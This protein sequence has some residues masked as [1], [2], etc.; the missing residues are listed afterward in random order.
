MDNIYH[1]TCIENIGDRVVKAKCGMVAW[2]RV[3]LFKISEKFNLN[4]EK[5]T[6][7]RSKELTITTISDIAI[8]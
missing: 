5:I 2:V 1:K 6:K 7:S 8:A 3:I 4:Q